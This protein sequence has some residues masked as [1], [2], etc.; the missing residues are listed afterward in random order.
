MDL[1]KW[2]FKLVPL[3][4][5]ALLLDCF[6]LACTARE[7][8]MRA[9]PYDLTDYGYEPIR[10]ETP[11]GRAEYVRGQTEITEH[12]RVLRARLHTACHDLLGNAPD[13]TW[14][15]HRAGERKP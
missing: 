7:L 13:R 5:S 4:D 9:S 6:E 15:D 10:I 3:V 14:Q 2:T 11:S 1:Y 12:A 8:D